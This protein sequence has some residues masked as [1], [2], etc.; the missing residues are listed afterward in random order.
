M[1]GGTLEAVSV[2]GRR[3]ALLLS[4]AASLLFG[5]QYVVIKGGIGGVNP[6]FFGALTMGIGGL[7]AVF[8]VSRRKRLD[9]RP[10]RR[11]EVWAGTLATTA[12]ISLQYIGL[13]LAPASVGGLIVG[14]NVIFVAPLSAII[15]GEI[16]GWKRALGVA[17]GLVGI[18]TIT[19]NWNI[20]SISSSQFT[21]Y[22]L[23]LGASLSIAA[24]YPLTKLAVRYMDN[25]EWVMAFHLTSAVALMVLMLLTGGPGDTASASVP[26]VLFVGLLCTSVPTILW[27]VGLRSLSM[28]TSA[29][30]LMSESVFAVILGTVVRNESMSALTMLGAILVFVAIFLAAMPGGRWQRTTL[31][32]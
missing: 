28:T 18:F 30:I 17:V 27:A 23:L 25:D 21:G 22:I 20:D 11:W 32:K 26:A 1:R 6:L 2:E 19:T 10:F 15:F 13:T 9:L 16:I 31:E 4:L 14:S 8:I 5:S 7:V 29:T 3:R 12:L 24:S